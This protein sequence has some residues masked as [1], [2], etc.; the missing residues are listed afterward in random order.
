MTT[1]L[2]TIETLEAFL[3]ENFEGRVI[4]QSEYMKAEDA[5]IRIQVLRRNFGSWNKIAKIL[6]AR[7]KRPTTYKLADI[8]LGLSKETVERPAPPTVEEVLK[9]KIIFPEKQDD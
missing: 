7:Q 6:L 3:S 8:L 9:P 4:S 5:P 2:Q 1:K